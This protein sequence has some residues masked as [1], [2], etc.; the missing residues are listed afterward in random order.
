[1]LLPVLV[2]TGVSPV[3]V[4]VTVIFEPATKLSPLLPVKVVPARVIVIFVAILPLLA[5]DSLKVEPL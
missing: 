2:I 3:G 1:M 4:F 5:S